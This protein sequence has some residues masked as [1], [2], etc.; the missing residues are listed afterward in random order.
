M[1]LVLTSVPALFLSGISFPW[2]TRRRGSGPSRWR[3]PPHSA[4][5]A[6]SRSARWGR[7][8]REA[9]R[10]WGALWL[11]TLLYGLVAAYLMGRRRRASAGHA[12]DLDLGAPASR[13]DVLVDL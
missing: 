6:S 4:F 9:L 2:E 12:H 10:S 8:W 1:A 11:Q 13:V 3:S 7:R 5:E